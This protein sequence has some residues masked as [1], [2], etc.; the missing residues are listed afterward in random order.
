MLQYGT[1]GAWCPGAA[2]SG[3]GVPPRSGSLA[4]QVGHLDHI[5]L[6]AGSHGVAGGITW[7]CR[8]DHVGLQAGSHRVAGWAEVEVGA[9]ELLAQPGGE[10]LLVKDVLAGQ[11]QRLNDQRRGHQRASEAASSSIRGSGW[12]P[13]G[14]AS[15]LGAPSRA[16]AARRALR[17]HRSRAGALPIGGFWPCCPSVAWGRHRAP[18]PC[19]APWGRPRPPG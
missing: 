3:A 11:L 13:S 15:R 1:G 4:R 9:R 17:R 18:S 6:Q 19:M 16:G 10:A 8:R 14:P 5:G 2:A 7:G 12:V